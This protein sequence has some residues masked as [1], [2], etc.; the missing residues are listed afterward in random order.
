VG[1]SKAKTSELDDVDAGWEDD[2]DDQG[3]DAG[4]DEPEEPPEPEPPQGWTP[5]QREARAARAAARKERLRA[6]AAEK[7]ERRK[8]RA[9]TAAAR[10]KKSA[11]RT[12]AAPAAPRGKA[13]RRPPP[14]PEAESTGPESGPG[15]DAEES[16]PV[17]AGRTRSHARGP[18]FEW[19]RVLPFVVILAVAIAVGLYLWKR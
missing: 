7:A 6:K 11:P 4:W 19:R 17:V 1:T 15:V 5:E 9:A 16:A 18:A 13:V 2:E 14:R 10:Q 3:V 12:K 8:A